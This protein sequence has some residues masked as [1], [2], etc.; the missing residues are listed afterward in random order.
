MSLDIAAGW[1]RD[2]DAEPPPSRGAGPKLVLVSPRGKGRLWLETIKMPHDMDPFDLQH[3]R[4]LVARRTAARAMR[5][6][7]GEPF[8]VVEWTNDGVACIGIT[9][10][11][12]GL[13]PAFPPD[14]SAPP[15]IH[16]DWYIGCGTNMANV[17]YR[18]AND[19]SIGADIVD[20]EEMVRSI[21]FER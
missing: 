11:A 20:C 10:V 13:G 2:L 14:P 5:P 1:A 15:S 16:R 6:F 7:R 19:D 9:V 8:D 17:W 12:G 3:L 18:C 21:R 4:S